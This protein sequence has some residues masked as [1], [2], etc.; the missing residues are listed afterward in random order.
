[1]PTEASRLSPEERATMRN[2]SDSHSLCY[3]FQGV[4]IT[5]FL[6]TSQFVATS[7]TRDPVHRQRNAFSNVG[8]WRVC[9]QSLPVSGISQRNAFPVR[10]SATVSEQTIG[11]EVAS[12]EG[13]AD[14]SCPA[15]GHRMIF[16]EVRGMRRW[17]R[18]P[19]FFLRLRGRLPLNSTLVLRIGGQLS[20]ES[21]PTGLTLKEPTYPTLPQL[22]Q[23]LRLA[24]HDPRISHIHMRVDSLLCGWGKILEVRR[25]LEYYAQSGKT[26]SVFMETGSEKEF[27]L[28]CGIANCEVY[29][30][31]EGGLSLRGF[32]ASGSFIRGVLEKIGVDPQVERIGKF[33]SAGDQ[34]GRKDMSAEQRSVLESLLSQM[35]DMWVSC[36]ATTKGMPREKVLDIVDQGLLEMKDYVDAGL[37]HGIKYEDEIFEDL[38]LRFKRTSNDE[39]IED[40]LKRNLSTTTLPRYCRRT[41]EKLLGL[42]GK[43][44]IAVI[45]ANGAIMSGTNGN[46]P[47]LGQTIGSESMLKRLAKVKEDESIKAVILRVD[48]P[49]GSALASDIIYH[50][51]QKLAKVKPVIAS[52]VDVAASGGYYI[53]MGVPIVAENS[54]LTG[55][56]G[57]VT[58]KLSLGDLYKRIGFSKEVLSKGRYA[59]LEVD[60]RSFTEEEA[61]YFRN[62]TERAYKSFVSKAASSRG[63]DFDTLDKVAQGRVWTGKQALENGLVDEVGGFWRAVELAKEKAGIEDEFVRLQEM[64]ERK[65]PLSYLGLGATSSSKAMEQVP[66]ALLSGQPLAICDVSPTL[67]RAHGVDAGL[68][69]L[70]KLAAATIF[71]AMSSV[72]GSKAFVRAAISFLL[73]HQ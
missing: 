31:P 3:V 68:S 37:I 30:P 21:P 15:L 22:C 65:S 33:K 53:S 67:D 40:I 62:S 42:G 10:C 54:T 69:P 1:M 48:S 24:A 17:M 25:H 12:S 46:S 14:L 44:K 63:V 58:A 45:R 61:T 6:R 9:P 39:N 38:K 27:F 52:M 26:A 71:E 5:S 50:A 55:S 43:K 70:Q 23:G 16:K 20:E 11:S 73:G 13:P 56:I 60:C 59:E 28:T 47:I 7:K 72:P 66:Q 36:V 49:G 51:V 64:R 29:V 32:S 57:V 18:G 41:S 2:A 8:V 34:L 19:R 35:Q 4:P